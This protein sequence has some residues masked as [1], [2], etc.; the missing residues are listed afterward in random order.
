MTFSWFILSLLADTN[1]PGGNVPSPIDI[2][3]KIA[4]TTPTPSLFV[5]VYLAVILAALIGAIVFIVSTLPPKSQTQPNSTND[6]DSAGSAQ[7]ITPAGT[8]SHEAGHG[9]DDHSRGGNKL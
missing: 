7:A 1:A 3:S 4:V 6:P 8:D 2:T 9:D 5:V